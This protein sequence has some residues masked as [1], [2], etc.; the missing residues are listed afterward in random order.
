M[1]RVQ[2]ENAI[3]TAQERVK[4]EP[5][6]DISKLKISQ[7]LIDQLELRMIRINQLAS[8]LSK[9][10][11]MIRDQEVF[12]V[13]KRAEV[14]LDSADLETIQIYIRERRD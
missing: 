7:R 13:L 6:F 11:N 8:D 5:Q 3:W 14:D 2:S 4:H 12:T 10:S 9:I 1:Q